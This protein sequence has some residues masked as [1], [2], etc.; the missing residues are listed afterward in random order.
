[1]KKKKGLKAFIIVLILLIV[2][3]SGAAI[4]WNSPLLGRRLPKLGSALEGA[5]APP[6]PQADSQAT[7]PDQPPLPTSIP[8]EGLTEEEL[9]QIMPTVEAAQT[10]V[11]QVEGQPVCGGPEVM[12][13][14][15]LGIDENEQADAIRLVRVDFVQ[16][17]V[18]VVGIPRDFY[19]PVV[20]FEDEGITIGRINATYG[21]G[22]K[23]D[24]RGQGI[25]SIANNIQHNF[26]IT[27]DHYLVLHLYNVDTYI[28]K[29][30]GIDLTLEKPASDPSHY[31]AAGEHH[32]TGEQAVEFMRIRYYDTDFARIN[33]Q[34]MILKAAYKKAMAEM[35]LVQLMGLA[36]QVLSDRTV[37]ASFAAKDIYPVACLAKSIS[38][39]NVHF[40]EIPRDMHHGF[41]T[42]AG[43]A[44]QIW[45]DTVP[46]FLQSVMNGTYQP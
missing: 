22:E 2:L 24:G 44:V 38:G 12:Y 30:G 4:A 39:E 5:L 23:F 15:V 3:G 34:T 1:M 46:G 18:H 36:L 21:Y 9:E 25:V 45:H 13:V 33:R 40:I 27:F 43:G 11:A 17:T 10:Q 7:D 28:D 32:F 16:Q 19:G 42:S 6:E 31:Y 20:G 14:L 29:L 26:G 35:N 41:T 8:L 37:Q